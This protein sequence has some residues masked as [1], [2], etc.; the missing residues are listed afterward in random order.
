VTPE[1]IALWVRDRQ[2]DAETEKAL[3]PIIA[4]KNELADLGQKI[5]AIER[6]QQEIARDQERIRGNL[7][8]LGQSPDEASLRQRYIRQ[9]DQQE[10][11]LGALRAERDKLETAR[12]AAQKQLDDLLQNLSVDRKV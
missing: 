4:K 3:G 5:A 7:Q 6:E 8:R 2:I 9:L 11:R 1:V 12:N 10:T